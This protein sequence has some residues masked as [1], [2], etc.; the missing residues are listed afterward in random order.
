MKIG[1]LRVL[2]V[3]GCLL[4]CGGLSGCKKDVIIR[5]PINIVM[6]VTEGMS[7]DEFANYYAYLMMSGQYEAVWELTEPSKDILIDKEQFLEQCK[8]VGP[9]VVTP[10][11]YDEKIIKINT[12]EGKQKIVAE[13]IMQVY[14]VSNDGK[15]YV[16]EYGVNNDNS[17]DGSMK[18]AIV[19]DS[20]GKLKYDI[21]STFYTVASID[22]QVPKNVRI[23]MNGVLVPVELSNLENI[24][25]IT[26]YV[27]AETD[28]VTLLTAL[29][30][31][32]FELSAGVANLSEEEELLMTDEELAA[33]QSVYSFDWALTKPEYDEIDKW[34]K[35]NM[36]SV[37]DT[38]LKGDGLDTNF[39]GV[40]SSKANKEDIK[41]AYLRLADSFSDTGMYTPK[42][43][44]C[45]DVR[46]LSV[47]EL[48]TLGVENRLVDDK[49]LEVNIKLR[50][51]YVNETKEG[52]RQVYDESYD[53]SVWLT[54]DEG[55][56]Y[57][58][59]GFGDKF[60]S[61]IY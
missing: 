5:D 27:K 57:K 49:S 52:L 61:S 36:Q 19:Q 47:E 59:M 4:L 11:R 58:F 13:D 26:K 29:G 45:V 50:Y 54:K 30:E 55:S 60:F 43:M 32:E 22:I 34:L 21:P 12:S 56:N 28:K 3:G 53:T 24:Y 38:I 42:D 39:G 41:P 18:V 17:V 20:E 51:S 10:K 46:L 2:V 9:P 48:N 16:V 15:E 14:S 25:H 44:R 40:L 23:K 1:V 8:L 31:K 7:A 35:E 33:V 6:S 37:F